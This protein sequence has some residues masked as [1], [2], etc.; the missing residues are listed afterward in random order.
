MAGTTCCSAITELTHD[1]PHGFELFERHLGR[2]ASTNIDVLDTTTSGVP[3]NAPSESIA[4]RS[5][6]GWVT[7]ARATS[8]WRPHQ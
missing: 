3:N 7:S 5:S 6:S 8:M 2:V 1:P 4:S